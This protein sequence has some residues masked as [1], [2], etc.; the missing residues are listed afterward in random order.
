[1]KWEFCGD[2]DCEL[3]TDLPQ[4]VD[5]PSVKGAS[6]YSYYSISKR[7]VESKLVNKKKS[8]KVEIYV[9]ISKNLG[10]WRRTSTKSENIRKVKEELK[11]LNSS[12]S[13]LKKRLKNM[14][15]DLTILK[16]DEKIVC[17][18]GSVARKLVC[19]ETYKFLIMKLKLNLYFLISP[20]QQGPLP[21]SSIQHLRSLRNR[22]FQQFEWSK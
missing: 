6:D 13:R 20:M 11:K 8:G 12:E 15:L 5:D 19:G 21:R 14:N 2:Q 9:K 4:C 22:I 16:L 7:D 3:S 1:M 10:L 17:N 18:A